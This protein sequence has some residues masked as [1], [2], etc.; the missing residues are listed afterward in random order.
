[1]RDVYL[2]VILLTA[3]RPVTAAAA[4]EL[5]E[6]E[7]PGLTTTRYEEDYSVLRNPG[8]KRDDPLAS[9]AGLK[10]IPLGKGG[11][12]YLSLGC[13]IRLRYES[14]EN[15]LW[16]DGPQDRGGYLW[17]RALP[18]ADF[19]LGESFRAFGQLISAFEWE[20]DTGRSP[21]DEDRFDVLQ[22]FV[23]VHVDSDAGS[24]TVR[25]GRQL[26]RYGS[27]RLIGVRYGPNVPQPFDAAIARIDR[28]PW[29]LDLFYARPVA[30]DSG[31]IDDQADETQSIWSAYA[32]RKLTSL[33]D[34]IGIDLYYIG[35][36][37]KDAA[38]AQD[39]GRELRHT[40]GTRFFGDNKGFDWNLECFYQFGTFDTAAAD[41]KIS[42]W[43]V[44]SSIGLTLEQ[45][46][47]RPRFGLNTNVISGDDD[48]DDPDLQTFN[49]L[50]PKGK[51]FG[52]IGLIGPYNIINIH[53]T[54]SLHLTNQ[55]TVDLACAFYWRY[56]ASDGVYDNGGNVIR[57][58]L[59]TSERFIGTQLEAVVTYTISREFE[60]SAAYG[61]FLPGR[62][63][64]ESGSDD[65]VHFVGVEF[66]Y[67]F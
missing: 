48:P 64:E 10:Y 11:E 6:P 15:N 47:L 22:A 26:L 50:F 7:L 38:F 45:V 41:G 40:L 29:R 56:S 33:G 54:L 39:N 61:T 65:V 24:I 5:P 44:A 9:F 66:S 17:G 55:L 16:G 8:R 58:G 46:A 18:Y 2:S 67:R 3:C 20:D 53:P 27:E 1:M 34:D 60:L 13:E 4:E 31:A 37:D 21:P 43:S 52:E 14:Y 51:Y 63:I 32:T 36:L 57:D 28:G 12:D 25:P 23:D 35:Y 19:H 62:F 30:I 49:A 42:A 59:E